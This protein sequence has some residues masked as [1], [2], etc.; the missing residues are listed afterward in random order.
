[1]FRWFVYECAQIYNVFQ[2]FTLF[3]VSAKFINQLWLKWR[4]SCLTCEITKVKETLHQTQNRPSTTIELDGYEM[5][6]Y[7]A[8]GG[9]GTVMLC[10]KHSMPNVTYVLKYINLNQL[11]PHFR[12]SRTSYFFS[13]TTF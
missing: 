11:T 10:T 5:G 12:G 8:S 7:L 2:N 4:G 9:C 13:R 1:M 6:D 3:L